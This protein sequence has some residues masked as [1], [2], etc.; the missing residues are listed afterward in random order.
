LGKKKKKKKKKGGALGDTQ[1]EKG[2]K[3]LR[4]KRKEGSMINART[5][6]RERSGKG[7]NK[8]L[9]ENSSSRGCFFEGGRIAA[10]ERNTLC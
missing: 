10:L 8:T 9:Y 6:T 1:D 4:T 2:G 5:K 3:L 7:K